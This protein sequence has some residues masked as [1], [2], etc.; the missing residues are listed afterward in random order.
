MTDVIVRRTSTQTATFVTVVREHP[1]HVVECTFRVPRL[2][3]TEVDWGSY[4]GR[5]PAYL[6]PSGPVWMR[7]GKRNRV[8]FYDID[9]AQVGPEQSNV[10][11]AVAYALT[12]G[13]SSL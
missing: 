7:R 2:P 9:G 13:W 6:T 12:E 3:E 5:S 8:R 11:P 10:A 4:Y 1:A